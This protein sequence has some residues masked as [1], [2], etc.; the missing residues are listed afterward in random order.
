M[1]FHG[2]GKPA[3]LVAGAGHSTTVYGRTGTV[4]PPGWPLVLAGETITRPEAIEAATAFL[5]TRRV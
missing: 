5:I 4:A 2:V 3:T 1:R